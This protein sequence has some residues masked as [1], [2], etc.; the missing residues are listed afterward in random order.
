MVPL[1]RLSEIYLLAAEYTDDFV[2]AKGYLDRIR[3]SRN[4]PSSVATE[5][6]LMEEITKECRREFLGE[7]QM[8]F[9]YKR[10]AMQK[11]PNG[12]WEKDSESQ[13]INMNINNYVV[14][15]P[16]SEINMRLN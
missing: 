13:T 6:T 8:F 7:G 16:D 3:N 14:P 5:P 4:C 12:K 1:I 15:L 11:I 10:K 2:T 9:F